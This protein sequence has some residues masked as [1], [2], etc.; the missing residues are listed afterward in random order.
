MGITHWPIKENV[1][2]AKISNTICFK[3]DHIRN[4]RY[5]RGYL[6]SHKFTRPGSNVQDISVIFQKLLHKSAVALGQKFNAIFLFTQLFVMF[7]FHFYWNIPRKFCR[8]DRA[9]RPGSN[10]QNILGIFQKLLHK[11]AAAHGQN[12][13]WD[14]LLYA[15]VCYVF[16][17]FIY[18]IF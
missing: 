15:A 16:V 1:S 8:L 10:V 13:Q 12:I 6:G 14:I 4:Q 3:D 2:W 18:G 5:L 9:L 7:L 11:S 17:P